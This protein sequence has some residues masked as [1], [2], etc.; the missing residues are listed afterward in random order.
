LKKLTNKDLFR[1]DEVASY[2]SVTKK[3]VYLWVEV[4]I[5]EA[6]KVGG[7]LRIPKSAIIAIQKP[8]FE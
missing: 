7:V 6:V 5:L 4:G 3:T 8:I 1:P 2:F